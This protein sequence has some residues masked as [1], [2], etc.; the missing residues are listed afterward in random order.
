MFTVIRILNC[1]IWSVVGLMLW[2]PL[3]TRTV[4]TFNAL[5]LFANV[6]RNGKAINHAHTNVQFATT[7]YLMGFANIWNW[8]Q[9]DGATN[10]PTYFQS[11]ARSI[12]LFSLELLW[13]TIWWAMALYTFAF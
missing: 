4:V 12:A 3:L 9:N 2:I 10:I 8:T 6:T 13:T 11:N 7:F 5:A 1:A